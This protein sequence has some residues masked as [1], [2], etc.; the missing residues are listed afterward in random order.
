[1]LNRFD[2]LSE[3][4]Q[5]HSNGINDY[6]DRTMK[7]ENLIQLIPTQLIM[8]YFIYN[9]REI[10]YFSLIYFCIIS[11]TLHWLKVSKTVK[12]RQTTK[13]GKE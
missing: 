11:L 10:F 5:F 12:R 7:S 9:D 3:K 6:M 2:F 8:F 13:T 4:D 1:M